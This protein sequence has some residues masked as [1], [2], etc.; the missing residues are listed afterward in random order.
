MV[1]RSYLVGINQERKSQQAS[2]KVNSEKGLDKGK[3]E[4][5]SEEGPLLKMWLGQEVGS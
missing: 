5:I 3:G 2:I 4:D 1:D